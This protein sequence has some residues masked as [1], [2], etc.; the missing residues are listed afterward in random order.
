MATRLP[1]GEKDTLVVET[2]GFRD[3]LWLDFIGSPLTEAARITE[4]FQ[5]V[6]YGNL[7][8]Q[9][10]VDDPKAYTQPWTV[11]TLKERL[12]PDTELL[13]DICMENRALECPVG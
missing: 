13:D 10:T 9:V 11:S 4:R 5:R 12:V 1:I 3:D 6:N 7:Q 8:I 2:A